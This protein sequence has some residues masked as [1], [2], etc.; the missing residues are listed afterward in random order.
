LLWVLLHS[1]MTTTN[2]KLEAAVITLR[3]EYV[4]SITAL[5]M[6][7]RLFGN[8]EGGNADVEAQVEEVTEKHVKDLFELYDKLDAEAEGYKAAKEEAGKKLERE[9]GAPAVVLGEE[10]DEDVLI[11][12]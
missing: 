4:E 7:Q 1:R 8:D 10:Y 6:K 9:I 12:V 3:K 11:V 2:R 5:A